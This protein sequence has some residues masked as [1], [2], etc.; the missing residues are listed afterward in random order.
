MLPESTWWRGNPHYDALWRTTT[1]QERLQSQVLEQLLAALP[2]AAA[3]ALLDALLAAVHPGQVQVLRT[4]ELTQGLID[5]VL[6]AAAR[7]AVPYRL[8]GQEVA[9]VPLKQLQALAAT[10]LRQMPTSSVQADL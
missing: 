5:V 1:A 10:D 8:N 3:Q 7:Q 4:A 9:L 2:E 6:A